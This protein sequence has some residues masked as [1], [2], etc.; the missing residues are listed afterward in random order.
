MNPQPAEIGDPIAD[1]DTPALIVDLDA[2]NPNIAKMTEFAHS[3]GVHARPHART[4]KSAAIALRQIANGAGDQCA[5]KV[6]EQ[7]AL[8]RGGVNASRARRPQLM[9]Q[10]ERAVVDA[11]LKSYSGERG[12]SWVLGLKDAELTAISD[13][14][15]K[16][17]RGPK[18]KRLSV[19]EK[20]WLI[21]GHRDPTVNL[22]TGMSA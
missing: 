9:R 12:P 4:H 5:Q 16:L 1:I 17:T 8:V 14:R 11:A 13:E 20:V 15:G 7:D 19:G 2:L 21:P 10:F 6:G 3:T 18:A 22:T